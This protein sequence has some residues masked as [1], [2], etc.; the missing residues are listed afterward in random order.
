MSATDWTT[1]EDLR[2]QVQR[3]WDN[4]RLLAAGVKGESLFPME[5]RLRG[6]DT[7]ALSERFE[8]VRQWIRGLESERR[9]AIEWR[10]VNHRL[11]GRNRVP[12]RIVVPG[13][14]EALELIGKVDDA[15]HFGR[16]AA[17]TREQ[18]PELM[19]WLG[20]KPLTG[21]A[22]AADWE[23]IL[24]VLRWF[25]GHPRC[26]LYL[27]Q[28][29]IG[30]VDTKF[31]EGRKVL[32][33]ELLDLVL[34]PEALDAAAA[35]QRNF[36]QRYGLASKPSQVRFRIL[37]PRL[38]IRGLTDLAVPAGEFAGLDLPVERVFITENEI[39][40][41]ASKPSQV[42]FRILDPR[43]SIRGLTDLAVPAGEFAGLDLPVE[44]VF[45]T[46]N[47]INGLAFPC[48]PGSLVIF[49][50]GYGLDRLS[51]AGWLGRRKLYYWGDIDTYGF[52]ILDRVRVRFPE[53]RSFLMDRQTL[54]ENAGLWV[55]ESDPYDGDLPRLTSVEGALYDDLR[56]NR[57]GERVRLEQER[58]PYGRV[59]MALGGI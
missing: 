40:G 6:P 58:I 9:Y 45:I 39:N 51:E 56:W 55:R 43:L 25:R 38:S 5:L 41:L 53:A 19:A 31:I 12:A 2:R 32:L 24:A 10:E 52:H 18:L 48:V 36:E 35:G 29:D 20:R 50:L 17:I 42:R 37:D 47:E 33:A 15:A 57:L 11:L 49:G 23:R 8:E 28:L 3:Q 46:E 26:G 13:E 14:R 59:E 27:R 30:G 16:V 44:R 54:V 34:P 1:P 22:H 4:G 21:L 7:R